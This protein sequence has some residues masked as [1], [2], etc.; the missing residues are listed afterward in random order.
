MATGTQ[1]RSLADVFHDI[2]SNIQDI[3]RSEFRLAKAEL[4]D[5]ASRARGAL[6]LLGSGALAGVFAGALLLTAC[7]LALSLVLA[8]WLSALIVALAA[9]IVAMSLIAAGRRRM[10]KV[11]PRPQRTIDSLRENVAWAKGQSK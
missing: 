7:V 5:Q 4:G 6:I 1:E 10:E 9:G 3:V 2:L 8:A 11:N